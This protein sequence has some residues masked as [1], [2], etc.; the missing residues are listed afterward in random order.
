MLSSIGKIFVLMLRGKTSRPICNKWIYYGWIQHGSAYFRIFRLSVLFN[1]PCCYY[2]PL[3]AVIVT[4]YGL[5][6]S[7][8]RVWV[9]IG[10]R[11]FSSPCHSYQFWGPPNLLCN[12]YGGGLFPVVKWPCHGADHSPST[13]AKVK[14]ML[15]YTSTPTYAFMA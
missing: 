6:G 8:V 14:N 12:G 11:I 3:Q 15:I 10:S 9:P 1:H 7:V 4:G 2:Y 13:S 5:D